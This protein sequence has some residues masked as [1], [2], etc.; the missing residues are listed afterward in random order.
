MTTVINLRTNFAASLWKVAFADT[1][2]RLCPEM[3]PDAADEVA[4]AEVG[5]GKDA[6]PIVAASR[7]ARQ[8]GFDDVDPG[9]LLEPS[10]QKTKTP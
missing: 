1:L 5:H 7:W 6:D 4:D 9:A 2:I 10:Q 8:H 3:N